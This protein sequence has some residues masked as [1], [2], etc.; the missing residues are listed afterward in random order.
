MQKPSC[1]RTTIRII[2]ETRCTCAA[3]KFPHNLGS[4][5]CENSVTERPEFCKP[6]KG[7]A[8]KL[9][10]LIDQL[11]KEVDSLAGIESDGIALLLQ[12]FKENFYATRNTDTCSIINLV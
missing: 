6:K 10:N 9:C 4:G 2:K 7:L 11:E 5:L 12:Q 8:S 3:Y 1:I